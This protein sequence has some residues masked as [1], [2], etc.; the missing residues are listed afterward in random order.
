MN[1]S[2]LDPTFY[3][4]YLLPIMSLTASFFT[5]AT[6]HGKTVIA[7]KSEMTSDTLVMDWFNFMSLVVVAFVYQ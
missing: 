5:L 6:Y 4:A 2:M 3:K 1:V 7:S